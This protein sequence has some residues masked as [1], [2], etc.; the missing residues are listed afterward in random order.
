MIYK[1]NNPITAYITKVQTEVSPG[2]AGSIGFAFFSATVTTQTG[3]TKICVSETALNKYVPLLSKVMEIFP[4]S[5]VWI[6]D[7]TPLIIK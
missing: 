2:F 6:S 1:N 4:C 3:G 7:F 5:S